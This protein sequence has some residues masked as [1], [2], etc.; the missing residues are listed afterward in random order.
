MKLPTIPR[1]EEEFALPPFHVASVSS[2]D[3][4]LVPR[5]KIKPPL[6]RFRV[7]IE[8]KY[9]S[10]LGKGHRIFISSPQRYGTGDTSP[11][12]GNEMSWANIVKY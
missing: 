8:E 3:G 5:L 4:F 2:K 7:I 10:K 12:I 11:S 6:I 9:V 1:G